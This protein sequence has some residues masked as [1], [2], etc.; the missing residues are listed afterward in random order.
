VAAVVVQ[1]Q[2]VV[3]AAAVLLAVPT[4]LSRVARLLL[5]PMAQVA[6]PELRAQGQHLLSEKVSTQQVVE[7]VVQH[8][9]PAELVP[10]RALLEELEVRQVVA[11]E[12]EQ[13]ELRRMA[14]WVRREQFSRSVVRQQCMEPVAAVAVMTAPAD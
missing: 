12:M 6:P 5:S 8:I 4:F 11:V 9:Q 1:M 14:A 3:V 7:Q 10:L 13:V 2:E